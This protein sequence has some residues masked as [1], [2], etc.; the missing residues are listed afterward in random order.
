M[1]TLATLHR[2][3]LSI[4]LVEQNAAAALAIADRAVVLDSGSVQLQGPAARLRDDP[5]LQALYLG[6]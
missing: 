1:D 6:G 3:G 5:E 2:D 4:L